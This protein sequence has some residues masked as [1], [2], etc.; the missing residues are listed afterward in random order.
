MM[1][2]KMQGA[3]IDGSTR[4]AGGIRALGFPTFVK[5]ITPR[6]YHYPVSPEYGSVNVPVVCGGVL[7]N[8][9]DLIIGDDDGVIVIP[10]DET[11]RLNQ[12]IPESL[13]KEKRKE[14]L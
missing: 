2:K 4:D 14:M 8:P 12:I 1:L 7:I 9:G 13:R 3:V 11:E 10:I 6:N 5:G